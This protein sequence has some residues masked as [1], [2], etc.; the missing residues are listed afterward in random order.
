MYSGDVHWVNL[1]TGT[2]EMTFACH[3]SI[4]SSIR[5]STD[6]SLLLTS[7]L[8]VRP[9]SALWR[10]GD[11]PEVIHSFQEDTEMDFGQLG[12]ERIIGTQMYTATVILR[13]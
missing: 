5:Q 10:L 13:E 7:S 11:A 6:G 2:T 8:Y 4:V 9:L 1:E 12:K 3:N